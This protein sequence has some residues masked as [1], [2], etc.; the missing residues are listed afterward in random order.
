MDYWKGMRRYE[1]GKQ[2][3][4]NVEQLTQLTK[5]HFV[6]QQDYLR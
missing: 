6:D 3:D 2:Q 4:F 5:R 1:L